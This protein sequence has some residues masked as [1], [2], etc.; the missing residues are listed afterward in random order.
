MALHP[1]RAIREECE[2]KLADR[3]GGEF[4]RDGAVE[5]ALQRLADAVVDEGAR[6]EVAH[7]KGRDRPARLLADAI[8]ARA[9]ERQIAFFELVGERERADELVATHAVSTSKFAKSGK[10]AR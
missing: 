8:I 2:P 5:P 9:A 3:G 4:C 1:S 6:A 7:A 10:A